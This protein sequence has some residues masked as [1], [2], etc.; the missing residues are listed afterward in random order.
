MSR[1]VY[2]SAVFTDVDLFA[3]NFDLDRVIPINHA[4]HQKT[5]CTGLAEGEDRILLRSFVLT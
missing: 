1:N 2:S 4:W 5:R 3:L